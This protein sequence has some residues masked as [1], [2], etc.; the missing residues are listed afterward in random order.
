MPQVTYLGLLVNAR[1]RFLS[2][3]EQ[4]I[5][6]LLSMLAPLSKGDRINKRALMKT[7]GSLLWVADVL[8]DCKAWLSEF[9]RAVS[10]HGRRIEPGFARI[11]PALVLFAG[12]AKDGSSSHHGNVGTC[13]KVWHQMAL[14]PAPRTDCIAS[15]SNEL[16]SRP[17]GRTGGPANPLVSVYWTIRLAEPGFDQGW[18][19]LQSGGRRSS[20]LWHVHCLVGC[21]SPSQ[22]VALQTLRRRSTR[23]P[24]AVRIR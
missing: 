14:C 21:G 15:A 1:F 18:S 4:R 8:K 12:R 22:D 6:K 17:G 24:W 9:Y 11:P 19:T 10:R 2:V 13:S 3:D 16:V 20:D 5:A 23:P 7:A